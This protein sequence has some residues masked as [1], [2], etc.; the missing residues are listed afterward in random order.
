MKTQM[1]SDSK[2]SSQLPPLRVSPSPDLAYKILSH[3]GFPFCFLCLHP[4]ITT[5]VDGGKN[6]LFFT[7]HNRAILAFRVLTYTIRILSFPI[8]TWLAPSHSSFKPQT[9]CHLLQED[10]PNFCHVVQHLP[11]WDP[12]APWACSI[13]SSRYFVQNTWSLTASPLALS[14][15]AA[16]MFIRVCSHT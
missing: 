4:H 3:P 14:S 16:T 1:K 13:Q 6:S 15:R 10:F 5:H 2:S 7:A 8:I 9:R 12:L 11:P